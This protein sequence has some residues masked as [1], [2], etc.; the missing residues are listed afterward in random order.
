MNNDER[1][2]AFRS[3]RKGVQQ[4]VADIRDGSFP[5]DFKG[6]SLEFVISCISEPLHQV[7]FAASLL[8]LQVPEPESAALRPEDRK[9]A[10]PVPAC[11]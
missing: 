2:K 9:M 6:S 4:V 10:G 11:R 7:D 5:N 1:L 3:I 8:Y